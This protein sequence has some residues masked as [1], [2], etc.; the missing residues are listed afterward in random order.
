MLAGDER[1]PQRSRTERRSRLEAVDEKP[2]GVGFAGASLALDDEDAAG[3]ERDARATRALAAPSIVIGPI[4]GMSSR[5]SC[6]RFGAFTSTPAGPLCRSASVGAKL[7]DAGQH[8]VRSL[9]RLDRQH[10]AGGDD[11]GLP[12][13]ET[14]TTPR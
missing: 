3:G 11:S 8:R 14:A 7:G 12:R 4:A 13:V 9:G 2:G 10:P 1:D 6:P 5:R